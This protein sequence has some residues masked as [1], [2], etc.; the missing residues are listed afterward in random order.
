M[1]SCVYEI[2]V[3]G[4]TAIGLD[5]VPEFYPI[6][7]RVLYRFGRYEVWVYIASNVL[8]CGFFDREIDSR[9]YI[10]QVMKTAMVGKLIYRKCSICQAKNYYPTKLCT[11]CNTILYPF[12]DLCIDESQNEKKSKHLGYLQHYESPTW[13]SSLRKGSQAT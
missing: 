1:N 6:K 11:N 9:M 7:F 3:Y 10:N 8:H 2:T 4:N 13:Y 12:D 5:S